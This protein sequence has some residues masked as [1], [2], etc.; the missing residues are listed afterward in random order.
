[1]NDENEVQIEIN[2]SGKSVSKGDRRRS[3]QEMV[4]ED[5]ASWKLLEEHPDGTSLTPMIFGPL[6]PL[7]ACQARTLYG[8]NH[9]VD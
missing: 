9:A 1:M 6:Q 2:D 7:G 8:Q 4:G 5:S 3:R